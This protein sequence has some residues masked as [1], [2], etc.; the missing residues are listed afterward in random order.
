[1][2][3]PSTPDTTVTSDSGL[4]HVEAATA[5]EALAVIHDRVGVGAEILEADKVLRGGMWGFFPKERVKLT[6]REPS[7]GIHPAR[8]ARPTP[9]PP[10]APPTPV[11]SD[12]TPP[13]E[14]AGDGLAAVLS[15]LANSEDDR[16]EGLG[17][18]LR[19]QLGVTIPDDEPAL[20]GVAVRS[21]APPAVG[22]EAP[23][24]RPAPVALE[25]PP[26]APEPPVTAAP[27][28]EPAPRA[29]DEREWQGPDGLV[30]SGRRL[31]ALGL[32]R[33]L[34]DGVLAQAP[35][36]DATWVYALARV[37]TPLCR[38]L[39]AGE[40]VLA[41]PRAERLSRALGLSLVR[42]SSQARG[43]ASFAAAVTDRRSGRDWIAGQRGARWLH[44]VIGG[45]DWRG[46][47]FDEPLAVSWV[48]AD[49]MT[50][51][52]RVA[53]DLGLVLGYGL[54]GRDGEAVRATPVELAM[55]IRAALA[56]T[57]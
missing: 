40:F 28:P 8:S 49:A 52:I 18:A 20:A 13:A 10:P 57:R 25:P 34:V 35:D 38:P 4:L 36:D 43:P 11:V 17:E 19:R 37:L 47:V 53:H 33:A 39:P 9:P 12:P 26:V 1:M 29:L 16:E 55:T 48:G 6:V 15:R 44:L 45:A 56:V 7:P 54:D 46:L 50:D 42:M 21:W 31:V 22:K 24:L 5:S 3:R 32:P 41:G 51:A 14:T 30:W 2:M 23:R 27:T